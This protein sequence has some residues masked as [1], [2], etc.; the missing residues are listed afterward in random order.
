MKKYCKNIAD[1]LILL[2]YNIFFTVILPFLLIF[3]LYRLLIRKETSRSFVQKLYLTFLFSWFKKSQ[4]FDIWFHAASVGELRSLNFLIQRN[5]QKKYHILI[6]TTTRKSAEIVCQYSSQY[7]KHSFLPIDFFLFQVLFFIKNRARKIIIADS[8]IWINFFTVARIF[9]T[10]IFLFNARMSN[11]SRKKW[12]YVPYVL[13]S[14]LQSVKVILPQG[15]SELNFFSKFHNNVRYFGNLKMM[16]LNAKKQNLNEKIV[17]FPKKQVLC[18][19]S[20]HEGEDELIIKQIVHFQE[21]FDIIYCP[22]HPHRA[23]DISKI[24]LKYGIKNSIFSQNIEENSCLVVDEIGLLD[25]V[26]SVAEIAIYGG[27]FLPHLKGHNVMEPAAFGC[28]IITG[29]FVETFAQVID[30]MKT[31]NAIIQCDSSEIQSKIEALLS[32]NFQDIGTNA[33]N[34]IANNMPNLEKILEELEEV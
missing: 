8:E 23:L 20:T 28:K 19:V 10:K 33:K 29:N 16:N 11:S 27:S 15:Y 5:I 26:F 1:F 24:L 31:H 25:S 14:V 6:T 13:H 17:K 32:G 22:R 21:Q 34:Y 2:I 9:R 30:E 7:V 18:V 4:N 3:F 12:E